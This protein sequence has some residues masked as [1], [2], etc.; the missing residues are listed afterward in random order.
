MFPFSSAVTLSL[1]IKQCA[2]ASRRGSFR[3]CHRIRGKLILCRGTNPKRCLKSPST[4]GQAV[5]QQRP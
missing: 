1:I 2:S 4:M 5:W 3:P